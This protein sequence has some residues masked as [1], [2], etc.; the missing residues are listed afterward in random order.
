MSTNP[1]LG[2]Y[3]LTWPNYK[4]H[5]CTQWQRYRGQNA[6]YV[7]CLKHWLAL[8]DWRSSSLKSKFKAIIEILNIPP[9]K[10]EHPTYKSLT[11]DLQKLNIHPTKVEHP[12]YKSWTSNLQNLN[13]QPTKVEH[14]TYKSWSS[15]LQKFIISDLQKVYHNTNS[16]LS[17]NHDLQFPNTNFRSNVQDKLN[18]G[19]TVFVGQKVCRSES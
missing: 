10:V 13:I 15:D 7:T 16:S 14:P 19:S 3:P 9:T 6:A 8:L 12:T 1:L 18:M 17:I 2:N 11:S 4:K 5:M